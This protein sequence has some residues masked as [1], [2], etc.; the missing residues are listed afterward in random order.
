MAAVLVLLKL[1]RTVVRTKHLF[2]AAPVE[3][4]E[5]AVKRNANKIV[6]HSHCHLFWWVELDSEGVQGKRDVCKQPDQE[7]VVGISVDGLIIWICL[8]RMLPPKL[9]AMS[10]ELRGTYMFQSHHSLPGHEA[11]PEQWHQG[12]HRGCQVG[13]RAFERK[14]YHAQGRLLT[15]L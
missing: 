3:S 5:A 13:D 14:V 8:F 7:H 2:L 15:K 4:V 10:E 9:L 12:L 1:F 11:H 6:I